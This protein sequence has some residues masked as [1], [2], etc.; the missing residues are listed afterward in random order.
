MAEME[1]AI[2]P[3][4]YRRE[5][6]DNRSI[7]ALDINVTIQALQAQRVM[8]R[9]VVPLRRALYNLSVIIPVIAN[10]DETVESLSSQISDQLN[11][12][13]QAVTEFE[14]QLNTFAQQHLTEQQLKMNLS[15]S[16]PQVFTVNVTSPYLM[17]FVGFVQRADDLIKTIDLLWFNRLITDV[18]AK[19]RR[20]DVQRFLIR[21]ANRVITF[22]NNAS[23][24]ARRNNVQVEDEAV[25][26]V[27]EISVEDDATVADLAS[28]KKEEAL[29]TA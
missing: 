21:G 1:N 10:N 3:S 29:A 28:D 12:L 19:N 2:K 20:F 22:A 5:T 13:G 26:D 7:P 6:A 25:T 14:T 8:N 15:Y 24:M 27:A 4:E 9:S 11:E 23:A 16:S 18:E 17:D